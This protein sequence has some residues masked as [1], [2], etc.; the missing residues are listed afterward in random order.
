[1]QR[2]P[3]CQSAKAPPTREH[4]YDSFCTTLPAA[5]PRP[6]GPRYAGTMS[7]SPFPL[8]STYVVDPNF[9]HRKYYQASM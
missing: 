6:L 7:Q 3:C 4:V 5:E 1:M 9:I 2:R 8:Y